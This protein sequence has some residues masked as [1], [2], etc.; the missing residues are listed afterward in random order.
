MLHHYQPEKV[1]M[2]QAKKKKNAISARDR[3]QFMWIKNF[4]YCAVL[5]VN[6]DLPTSGASLSID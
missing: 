6:Q 3:A 4:S 1:P 5:K 2:N